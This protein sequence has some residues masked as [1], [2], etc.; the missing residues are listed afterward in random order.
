MQIITCPIISAENPTDTPKTDKNCKSAIPIIIR[1]TIR[2]DI[3][4]VSTKFLKRKEYLSMA[5][6]A[7]KP[8]KR[9]R[10]DEIVATLI[11]TINP[12]IKFGVRKKFT[13]HFIENP[14]GGQVKIED[15]VNEL[16]IIITIGANVNKRIK[17]I[18]VVPTIFR[19]IILISIPLYGSYF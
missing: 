15:S 2:G 7:P 17:P 5:R 19:K 1:G 4:N 16:A 8:I 13:N 12:L 6:A 14:T 10:N 3:R 11:L 9:E 18:T